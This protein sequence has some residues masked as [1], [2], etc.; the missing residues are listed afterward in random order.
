MLGESGA[1][2]PALLQLWVS[3][4]HQQRISCLLRPS[5]DPSIHPKAAL[6][7]SSPFNPFILQ[8]CFSI[9]RAPK[10][11]SFHISLKESL[12]FVFL[13]PLV[14]IRINS[15]TSVGFFP[16]S[17]QEEPNLCISSSDIS[18]FIPT[19]SKIS[20]LPCLAAF[21]VEIIMLGKLV[22]VRGCSR[23][24]SPSRAIPLN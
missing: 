17:P 8:D 10:D 22:D 15:Q 16:P 11:W 7:L 2:P 14:T 12:L 24:Q 5:P 3:P 6:L 4:A 18:I 1:A 9:Y 13:P 23:A 21:Q 20:S 19:A